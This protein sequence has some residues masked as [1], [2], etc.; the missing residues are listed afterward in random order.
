MENSHRAAW[1]ALARRQPYFPLLNHQGVL[2]TPSSDVATVDFLATGEAD[3]SSLLAAAASIAGHAIAVNSVLDFG[4][5]VGRLTLPFARRATAVT[6]CDISPTMLEHARRNADE[7]GLR[8]VA[9]ISDEELFALRDGQFDLVCSLLVLQYV[10]RSVG[11]AIIRTLLRLLAPGGFGILHLTLAPP[12]ES[13]RQLTRMTR[14]RSRFHRRSPQLEQEEW[15]P[16]RMRVYAY[17]E[18]VVAR[19]IE[20]AGSRVLAR[21]AADAQNTGAVLIIEKART[22]ELR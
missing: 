14:D 1:E 9:Y 3:V 21:L 10:P 12:G 13:L 5:G 6:A 16:D 8:N 7:A 2:R 19:E 4:C 20:A 22:Q 11:Y 18:L 15:S 17:D